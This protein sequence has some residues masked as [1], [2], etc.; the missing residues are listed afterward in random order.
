MLAEILDMNSIAVG[1]CFNSIQI[2]NLNPLN[3]LIRFSF[4]K[5]NMIKEIENVIEV[6]KKYY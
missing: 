5:Y 6:L 2:F 1:K 4:S 3:P